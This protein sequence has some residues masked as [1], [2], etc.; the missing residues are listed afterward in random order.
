MA[1]YPTYEEYA[2]RGAFGEGIKRCDD[3]LKKSPKD[4][5]LL[6]TKLQ[7]LC[8]S[9]GD[10]SSVLE[11]LSAIQPPL[12]DLRELVPI[13]ACI[14]EANKNVFPPPLTAGPVVAKLWDTAN[15]LTTKRDDKL[16]LL[17]VRFSRAV[18]DNRVADAQ[19]ALIAWKAFQPKDRSAYMAHAAYTQ[20]LSTSKE[21]MQSRLALGLARKAVTERFDDDKGLDCRVPG[22][23][24]A[25]QK[26]EKDL[27]GIRERT[28]K[29]SKHVYDA[30]GLSEPVGGDPLNDDTN[31]TVNTAKLPPREWL[32]AEVSR[33]KNE[34]A[35]LVEASPA[36]DKMVEFTTGVVRLLHKA[37]T[38]LDLARNRASADVCF[39]A[40]SALVKLY[41][42]SKE[43][44]YLLRAAFLTEKLLRHNEHVHEARLVL[45]YIYMRLQLGSLAMHFFDS[46]SVKE[47]QHDTVGH[48]LF[49]RLSVIHPSRTSLPSRDWFDPHERT[50]KALGM[51]GRHED[52]LSEMEA[53][54][55]EHGQS[56]MIFDLNELRGHLCSSLARRLILLEHRRVARLTGKGFGKNTSE[57]GPRQL[58]NW[59]DLKDSRDFNA[60]FDYGFNIEKALYGDGDDMVGE[61]WLHYTLAADTA[62]CLA[63][64]QI[65]LILDS[66]K[67]VEVLATGDTNE[68]ESG[69]TTS[70]RLT[71]EISRH[72]LALLLAAKSGTVQQEH[73]DTLDTAVS[74][75]PIASLVSATDTL[76]EHLIDHYIYTDA[77]RI[78]ISSCKLLAE[79]KVSIDTKELQN[80]SKRLIGQLQNHAQSQIAAIRKSD[81]QAQLLGGDEGLKEALLLFG[82]DSIQ[83]F[84]EVVVTSAKEGWEGVGRITMG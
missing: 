35:Q 38:E 44:S 53:S 52:K 62:S 20:L 18:I 1:R 69:L 51:Y 19:Q 83:E 68:T 13:E 12:T 6:I 15:K 70:E 71:G 10:W 48:T 78:V 64:K 65:P 76:V 72:T 17:S 66:E 80:L 63:S 58:A 29:D 2:K 22:Q 33:L 77:L 60:A 47:I 49:T 3:L 39:L 9:N 67:L 57:I 11:Q 42:I 43:D 41:T 25:I 50:Y 59:T 54:V 55:L 74:A 73:I 36:V 56:G 4:T 8:N 23:I 26:A 37:L 81:V 5:H 46:L 34:F 30:L 16:D 28:F 84:A 24:F 40:V 79:S 75:L 14:V 61:R 45:V 82:N 21:D 32:N 7:L 31:G 27:E